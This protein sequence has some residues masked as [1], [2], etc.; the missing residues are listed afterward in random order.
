M[1]FLQK[2]T[3]SQREELRLKIKQEK[4]DARA[5]RR[6][7][8]II[9]L[10]E[11][12]SADT[13]EMIS[14][15]KREVVVKLRRIYLKQGFDALRSKQKEKAPKLLLTRDQKSYIAEVLNTKKPTDFGFTG[16]AFWTTGI[17]AYLIKEQ[18]GVRYKS[19]T[20]LYLI[21]KQAKF[22]FRKPEKQSEKRDEKQIAEWKEKYKPIIEQECARVDTI[23]LAGD[24]AVLTSMTR[25]QKVWLPINGPAIVQEAAKRKAVHLYGFL[26]IQSG[27]AIAYKT[28]RQ[29]G[30]ITVSILKK[31]AKQY[32][33]KRIVIFWD[34]AIWHKSETVRA[35][36]GST[37]QF[38]LYNFPPYAPDLNPQEH[39]W[40]EMRDKVLSNKLIS[41]I[42]K[43]SQ[44]AIAF[45]ENS[46]F[47]YKFFGVQGTFNM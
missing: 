24:E 34:N 33:N 10:E 35:Y 25:I 26:N 6:A 42:E 43:A 7:Q 41:N 11:R 17:L 13:I 45:I 8:A 44:D 32:M 23:V 21:F 1:N 30:D 4:D 28:E 27:A 36:L 31:L 3:E 38:Q 19:K 5:V 37:K 46:I 2:M 18:Y 20:S 9:L 29:T 40:K 14:G 22:T 16:Y 39:V 15:Y 12:A 47:K